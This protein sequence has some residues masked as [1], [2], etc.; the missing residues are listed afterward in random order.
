MREATNGQTCYGKALPAGWRNRV[1]RGNATRIV[2]RAC[3]GQ[4]E[5]DFKVT[6][7]FFGDPAPFC[8]KDFR[9]QWTCP[10][11][12]FNEAIAPADALGQTLH[13]ACAAPPAQ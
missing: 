5:C 12:R 9:I 3:N 2:A 13:F 10:D 11:S 8:A 1:T 6:P 4:D 7:E